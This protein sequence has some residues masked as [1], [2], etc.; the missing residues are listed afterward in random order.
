MS[1][2]FS[3]GVKK[4]L[5]SSLGLAGRK[6]TLWQVSSVLNQFLSGPETAGFSV[7]YQPKKARLRKGRVVQA[8]TRSFVI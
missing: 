6:I 5:N 8:L 4:D 7:D 1:V 2:K 3:T